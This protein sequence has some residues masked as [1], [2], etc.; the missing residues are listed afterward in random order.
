MGE[1]IFKVGAECQACGKEVIVGEFPLA[2]WQNSEHR[3]LTRRLFRQEVAR[4]LTCGCG[5]PVALCTKCGAC[6]AFAWCGIYATPSGRG[7]KRIRPG[8]L[9]EFDGLEGILRWMRRP[10]SRGHR[11]CIFARRGAGCLLHGT[12]AQPMVCVRFN[13]GS[14]MVRNDTQH[15]RSFLAFKAKWLA[16]G[17]DRVFRGEGPEE[18]SAESCP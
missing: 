2:A 5:E 18:E 1:E 11:L 3:A 6:C 16:E 8:H 10:W 12:M 14:P 13:C 15:F 9:A 7:D 17:M 4:L